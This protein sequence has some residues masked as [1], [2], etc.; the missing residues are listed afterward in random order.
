MAQKEGIVGD[1]ISSHRSSY[2][3]PHRCSGRGAGGRFQIGIRH[4][5][6]RVT[7]PPHSSAAA[8]M[9]TSGKAVP[10][11]AK[12]AVTAAAVVIA[13]TPLTANADSR[14]VI[15]GTAPPLLDTE[16]TRAE[17][18][19]DQ[20]VLGMNWVLGA[21]TVERVDYPASR[22]TQDNN[23][24][25]VD[26]IF[27]GSSL[28]DAIVRDQIAADTGRVTIVGMSQGAM[29]ADLLMARWL[30]DPS[31][32]SPDDVRFVL[33]GDPVR[34]VFRAFSAGTKIPL[35][36]ITVFRPVDTA[37]DV[38]VIVGEY[39]G[40][41]DP[42]DRWWNLLADV[43]AI[44]GMQYVHGSGREE[45]ASLDLT[46]VLGQVT[47]SVGGTTTTYLLPTK[48]LPLTMPLRAT[49]MPADFVDQ[50]DAVLRPIVDFAYTR[51]DGPRPK[52]DTPSETTSTVTAAP[53][54]AASLAAIT[55]APR[56]HAAAAARAL[57]PRRVGRGQRT[58]AAV[59]MPAP[60]GSA[61]DANSL[62]ES[63]SVSM[64]P[65]ESES[66]GAASHLAAGKQFVREVSPAHGRNSPRRA[67]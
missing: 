44:L 8:P 61:A 17:W 19:A 51:N 59:Q 7:R 46:R 60:R 5:V 9:M 14:V 16:W 43:N 1:A 29:V 63:V 47:N 41:G 64:S 4:R 6:A 20:L 45:L 67:R 56:I 24:P 26:S 34:G 21:S 13:A 48:I 50:L 39:D 38:D 66:V 58:A 15:G 11:W 10:F 42:P 32:P 49:G 22:G 65:P 28:T 12:A 27:I 57:N 3:S 62:S 33:M 30:V 35:V 52:S 55:P 2:F 18:W 23:I 36:D 54:A 25:M 37:Y 53:G 31:A 40:L